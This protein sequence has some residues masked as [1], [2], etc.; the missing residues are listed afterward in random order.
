MPYVPMLVAAGIE[1]FIGLLSVVM[2]ITCCI[3]IRTYGDN[4]RRGFWWLWYAY[5]FLF[6]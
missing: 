2:S 6:L 4:A 1:G 5:F 3:C